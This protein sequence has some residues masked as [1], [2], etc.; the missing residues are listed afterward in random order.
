MPSV[1]ELSQWTGED[2]N[3]KRQTEIRTDGRWKTGDQK[4]APAL[5]QVS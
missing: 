1:V 2:E 5:G 3:V 4:G